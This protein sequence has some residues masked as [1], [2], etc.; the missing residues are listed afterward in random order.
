[1]E[2]LR[3]GDIVEFQITG[4]LGRFRGRVES[5]SGHNEQPEVRCKEVMAASGEWTRSEMWADALLKDGDYILM[6]SQAN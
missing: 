4:V 1:M 5:L 2:M 6:R 3:V